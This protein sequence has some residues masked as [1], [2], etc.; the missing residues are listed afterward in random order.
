MGR[1]SQTVSL[2]VPRCRRG[3][4]FGVASPPIRG[5]GFG[6]DHRPAVVVHCVRPRSAR[7]EPVS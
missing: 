6:V 5:V 3:V 4:A 2:G 1:L 7:F